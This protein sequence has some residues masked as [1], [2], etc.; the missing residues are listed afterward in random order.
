MNFQ[1]DN[2]LRI[3]SPSFWKEVYSKGELFQKGLVVHGRQQYAI[4]V[5]FPL[6][7]GGNGSKYI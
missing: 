5:A 3:G 4:K 2:S 6:K 1:G 7:K